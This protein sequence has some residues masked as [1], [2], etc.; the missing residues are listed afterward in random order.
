MRYKDRGIV[1]A[2]AYVS[3]S[4]KSQGTL[5]LGN[6][7]FE[8]NAGSTERRYEGCLAVYP[9]PSKNRNEDKGAKLGA[10]RDRLRVLGA[11]AISI[12]D[13]RVV[14]PLSVLQ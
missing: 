8:L 10:Y 14:V 1:R 3:V 12:A 13:A 11:G 5:G 7:Q 6:W 4:Y 9:A 2:L